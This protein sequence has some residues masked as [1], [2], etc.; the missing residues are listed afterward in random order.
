MSAAIKG[1][2][3]ETDRLNKIVKCLYLKRKKWIVI[4]T[5]R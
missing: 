4:I 1:R 3:N 2:Y 5:D